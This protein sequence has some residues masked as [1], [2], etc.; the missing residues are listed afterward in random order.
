LLAPEGSGAD[1]LKA[2][3]SISRLFRGSSFCQKLRGTNNRDA[4]FALLSQEPETDRALKAA[5]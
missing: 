1:H 2:L 3:A 5:S 4:L